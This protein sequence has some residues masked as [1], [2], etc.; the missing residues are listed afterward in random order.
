[1]NEI[2]IFSANDVAARYKE[3]HDIRDKME[4]RMYDGASL[5]KMIFQMNIERFVFYSGGMDNHFRIER[6]ELA[7]I[8]ESGQE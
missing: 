4:L 5:F 3:E 2:P 6:E 1:M 8:I 7:T